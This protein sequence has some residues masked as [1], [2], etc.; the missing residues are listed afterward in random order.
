VI[1]PAVRP[2]LAFTL[3]GASEDLG[4][5]ADEPVGASNDD[6]GD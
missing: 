5:E 1:D 3:L 4:Q 6:V 2:E